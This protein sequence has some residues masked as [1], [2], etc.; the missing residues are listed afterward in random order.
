M[1]K[2]LFIL[3]ALLYSAS[4][5]SQQ[6]TVDKGTPSLN[7]SDKQ[8]TAVAIPMDI[9]ASIILDA[10]NYHKAVVNGVEP[11]MP[12]QLIEAAAQATPAH[13]HVQGNVTKDVISTGA[14]NIEDRT[15]NIKDHAQPVIPK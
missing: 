13:E 15:V 3:T 10:D 2:L 14:I 1:N 5:A 7:V 9:A 11:E 12:G 8:I 4:A 6:S